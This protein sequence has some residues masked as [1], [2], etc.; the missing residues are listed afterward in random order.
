M[1]VGVYMLRIAISNIL[2]Y[3]DETCFRTQYALVSED[4]KKKIDQCA[5]QEDK[6]RSL[7]AYMLLRKMIADETARTGATSTGAELKGSELEEDTLV[8]IIGEHGK[9]AIKGMSGFHFNLSHS[10]N[11][12]ACVIS[13]GEVGIDIQNRTKS[14][15]RI[16][17]R[18]FESWKKDYF[19][20]GILPGTDC[21]C[22]TSAQDKE[23]RFCEMWCLT[24]SQNK[25]TGMGLSKKKEKDDI[26]M[27]TRLFDVDHDYKMAVS[28]FR[29]KIPDSFEIIHN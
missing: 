15:E 11:Y 19:E 27:S 28:T 14:N 23:M 18:V 10:G 8:F 25:L 4:R 26:V 7:G 22:I 24:E 2:V 13:D 3:R 1:Q 20:S 12:V 17:E 16:A 6:W 5:K 29:G 21:L 9:P